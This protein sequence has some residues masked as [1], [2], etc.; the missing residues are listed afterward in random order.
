MTQQ[1][2]EHTELNEP[3]PCEKLIRLS[4]GESLLF[5]VSD[6]ILGKNASKHKSKI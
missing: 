3:N 5:P 6:L 2:H 1:K 4:P